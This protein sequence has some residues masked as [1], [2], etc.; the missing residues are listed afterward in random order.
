M[1]RTWGK[2]TPLPATHGYEKLWMPHTW[3]DAQGQ[4]GWG[5]GQH[6]LIAGVPAYGEVGGWVDSNLNCSVILW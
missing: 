4:V 6:G 3:Q 5:F 2:A 1:G